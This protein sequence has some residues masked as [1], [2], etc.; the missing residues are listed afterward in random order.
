[1]IFFVEELIIWNL[2]FKPKK[3]KE[4]TLIFKKKLFVIPNVFMEQP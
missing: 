1:M 2:M 4:I 3:L